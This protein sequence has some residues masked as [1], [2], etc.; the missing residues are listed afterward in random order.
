MSYIN[1]R[2]PFV[3]KS[4]PSAPALIYKSFEGITKVVDDNKGVVEALVNSTDVKDLQNDVMHKG[5][6]TALINKMA[7]RETAWPSILFGHN[8]ELPV[9][10]VESAW[11][12]EGGL[13]IRGRFN[14]STSRG[15]DA[16]QDVKFG[17]IKEWSV[18][19]QP[20]EH[21]YESDGAH[22]VYAVASWPEVSC[23]ILGA[24]PNTRTTM[25]KSGYRSETEVDAWIAAHPAEAQRFVADY[26]SARLG[27]NNQAPIPFSREVDPEQRIYELA[28]ARPFV[29]EF[30][31]RQLEAQQADEEARR[32]HALGLDKPPADNSVDMFRSMTKDK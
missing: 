30:E 15:H 24:S 17:S 2:W 19:F 6:W 14:L 20:G 3:Q 11:E 1:G 29:N 18:G 28:N 10:R 12:G 21:R 5:C 22:H 25:V 23:T 27:R 32:L 16:Y 9:G 8:W 13:W 26:V 4:G 31:L 7:T